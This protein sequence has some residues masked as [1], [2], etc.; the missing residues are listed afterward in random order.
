[1]SDRAEEDGAAEQ[2]FR[3]EALFYFKDGQF[4]R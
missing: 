3:P 1:M 2:G 4:Y